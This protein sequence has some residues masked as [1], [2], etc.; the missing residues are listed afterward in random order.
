M[1][2]TRGKQRKRENQKE[3]K[4]NKVTTTKIQNDNAYKRRNIEREKYKY[5]MP[6]G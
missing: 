2:N 1:E 6:Y 3:R 5:N 4:K